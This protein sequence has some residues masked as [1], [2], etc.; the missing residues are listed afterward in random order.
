MKAGITVKNLKTSNK[1]VV[2][3][4][5]SKENAGNLEFI[6]RGVGKA[7]VSGAF[8]KGK[9]KISS[10]KIKVTVHKYVSPVKTFK[11]GKKDYA[12]LFKKDGSPTRKLK[13]KVSG[14]LQIKAKKGWKIEYIN[15]NIDGKYHESI[16]NGKKL[17]IK[18]E[19]SDVG[20]GFYNQKLDRSEYVSLV[21]M[22]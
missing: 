12:S 11:I 16:K 10:F 13:G 1:K 7:T 6:A 18:K 9:K 15:G 14:K 2:T 19:F 20:V 4:D 3:V 22:K 17:T 8:Y 21:F 5:W